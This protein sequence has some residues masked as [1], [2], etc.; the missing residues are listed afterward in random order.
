[1]DTTFSVGTE[2]KHIIKVH[3]SLLTGR[4]IVM[5][6][7]SEIARSENIFS[8]WNHLQFKI[9]NRE[10]HQIEVRTKYDYIAFSARIELFVDGEL[11]ASRDQTFLA[12]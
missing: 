6:D 5:A 3:W 10:E 11:V 2:E 12:I 1:M 7:D 8:R 4:I 9:G